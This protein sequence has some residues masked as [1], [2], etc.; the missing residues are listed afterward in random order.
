MHGERRVMVFESLHFALDSS[1][2][3]I[4]IILYTIPQFR[5]GLLLRKE[6]KG[7]RTVEGGVI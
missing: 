4:A 6:W 2:E 7:T 5:S 1:K 3:I